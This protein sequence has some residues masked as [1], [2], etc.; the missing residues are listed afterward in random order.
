MTGADD[1]RPRVCGT[2]TL[3]SY[4]ADVCR[5][6]AWVIGV[7]VLWVLVG[8]GVALVLG[9]GIHLADAHTGPERPFTTADLP[10]GLRSPRH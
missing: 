7:V 1:Q 9:R 4:R 3:G 5:M 2:V 8:L 6:E 10:T